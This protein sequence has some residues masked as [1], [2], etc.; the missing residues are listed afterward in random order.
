ML[1][2]TDRP[3]VP[4]VTPFGVFLLLTGLASYTPISILW[5][6]PAK[7][8][9]VGILLLV[10]RHSYTKIDPKVSPLPILMGLL[11]FILWVLP[12]GHYPLLSQPKG[13]N[14][15]QLASQNWSIV[16]IGF[17]LMGAVI[18]VPI[19]EE[20]FWRSFLMR[21]LI[22][23]DFKHVSLGTF[24]WLSFCGTV[25]LFG[26]EHYRWLPGI[27]AGIIYTLLLY[28]KKDLFACV[29]A[30]STTNLALGIY[31]LVSHQWSYW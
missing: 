27:A 26:V 29:L 8:I 4:Y 28:R 21:Y 17:R 25:I 12:E 2:I 11:V 1:K 31:V 15:Y 16:W 30:H 9:L 7:T 13:M 6:Y 5:L 14:P 20:L 3:I 18:V 10:F 24:G 19:M 23:P 22:D